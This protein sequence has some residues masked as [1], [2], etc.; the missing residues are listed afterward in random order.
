LTKWS[1]E[2]EMDSTGLAPETEGSDSTTPTESRGTRRKKT[3]ALK[4][5]SSLS[6]S[7]ALE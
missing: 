1:P 5:D 4:V 6:H 3:V 7:A 2:I